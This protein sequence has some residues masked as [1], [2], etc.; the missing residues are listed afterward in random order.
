M[1]TTWA[2]GSSRRSGLL[3]ND[4]I[5]GDLVGGSDRAGC[6]GVGSRAVDAIA[7]GGDGGSGLLGSGGSGRDN[8]I[9]GV[10]GRG[11]N[12]DLLLDVD[13]GLA[14]VIAGHDGG[15]AGGALNDLSSVVLCDG[16]GVCRD[17]LC[18][19][20]CDSFSCRTFVYCWK[21]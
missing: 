7:G 11:A 6:T 8:D 21:S 18:A 3:R 1:L 13:D 2:L 9:L 15:S 16:G 12:A 17:D 19:A 14:G 4:S 5:D 10:G 20:D